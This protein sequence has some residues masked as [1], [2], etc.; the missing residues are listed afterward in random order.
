M[1]FMVLFCAIKRTFMLRDETSVCMWKLCICLHGD[2]DWTWTLL[3]CVSF[4]TDRWECLVCLF[5]ARKWANGGCGGQT[6][7]GKEKEPRACCQIPVFS[8]TEVENGW[9]G[10]VFSLLHFLVKNNHMAYLETSH[11][12]QFLHIFIYSEVRM[13]QAPR[14]LQKSHHQHCHQ[15]PSSQRVFAGVLVQNSLKTPAHVWIFMNPRR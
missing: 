14:W 2:L 11:F 4:Q 8:L 9:P 10:L 1:D 12:L 3:S 5:I 13:T 6:I 7:L 15:T